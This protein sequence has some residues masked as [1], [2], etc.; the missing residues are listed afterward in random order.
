MSR[1][2]VLIYILK[3]DICLHAASYYSKTEIDNV[4]SFPLHLWL[5]VH[6]LSCPGDYLHMASPFIVFSR[7]LLPHLD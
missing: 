4:L 3:G 2:S 7:V 1:L 5:Q 6:D